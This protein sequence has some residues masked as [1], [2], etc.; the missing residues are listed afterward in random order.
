M[1]LADSSAWIE[2]LRGGDHPV[3]AR[4]RTLVERRGVSIT[5]PVVMEVLAGVPIR[6]HAGI[7]S[8]LVALPLLPTRGLDDYEAAARI[9]QACRAGGDTPRG[10]IDCLIAAVAIREGAAVLHH[11]RD[12]DVIARHT[13]LEINPPTT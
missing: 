13:P 6:S 10:L 1:V 9:Y 7:R 2:F 8:A 4:L 11:D 3:R 12:F 5:E